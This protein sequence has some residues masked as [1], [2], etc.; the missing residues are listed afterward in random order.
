MPPYHPDYGRAANN[1]DRSIDGST[2]DSVSEDDYEADPRNLQR[3]R[4]DSEGFAVRP[5]GREEMLA[6]YIEDMAVQEGRYERY[7]PEPM[8]ESSGEE[9]GAGDP[10]LIPNDL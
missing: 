6:R 2:A 7:V 10:A 8:S 9:A 5:V 1:D 4:R 3:V